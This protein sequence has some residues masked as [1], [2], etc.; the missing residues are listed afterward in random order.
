MP[1]LWIFDIEPHEQ[2]YTSEWQKYLPTQLD[3]YLTRKK[4]SQWRV[5]FVPTTATSGQVSK[6]AFLD[7]AETNIYKSFQVAAFAKLV[8]ENDVHRGDRVLFTDA[9]HPGVIQCRY[10]SNMLN[11]DLTIDVIWHAGSYDKADLL[12]TKSQGNKFWCLAFEKGVFEAADRNYFATHFHKKMFIGTIKPVKTTSAKVVGWPMEYLPDLLKGRD[13]YRP[14]DVILF[15]HRLSQEKQPSMLRNLAPYMKN[16]KIVFA[17][18]Q[19]LSKP[20]YHDLLSRS[21]VCFSSST[22]ETLGIGTY[23]AMLCGAFPI[24]PKRLAYTEIYAGLCYP[25]MWTQNQAK[26]QQY[27]NSLANFI[28]AS[29]PTHTPSQIR[30]LALGIGAQYFDGGKLYAQLFRK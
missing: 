28:H 22:Q 17:Q 18:S 1:T 19:Q 21:L 2:R 10:M 12:A 13:Q 5:V 9:W 26:S 15:P 8:K 30:Q 23:E 14:K 27:E 11:L 7:F 24:V 20:D 6:N 3:S 4:N 16:Y 29:I 25:A